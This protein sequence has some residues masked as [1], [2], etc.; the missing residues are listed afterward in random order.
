V[1]GGLLTDLYELNM[2]ASYLRRGM[3]ADATFSLYVRNLPAERGFLVAAGLEACLDLLEDFGFTDN[4]LAYLGSIGFDAR[5]LEDFG[6]VSFDGEVWAVPEGT[7]VYGEEPILEV[8]APIAVAQLVETALL[9][10]ITLHTTIASKAARYIVAAEGRRVVDFAFRR[11]HGAEAAM[12]V[13]RDSSMV[14]FGATSN[15]EA[16]RRY[17]LEVAGTMAHSFVAAFPSE[18]D[19]FVAFAEDHP[20]RTTFLVDTYDTVNGVRTAI[21]VARRLGLTERLA[22]RLDSGDLDDLARASRKLL[23]DAGLT[24]ARIFASGGLDEHEVAELVKA[25]APVD[26]FGIGTQLGVSADAPYVDSVYKLVEYDGEPTMKLS[27]GKVSAPGRKQVWRP[28]DGDHADVLGLRDEDAPEGTTPLL[29][30]V[31]RG[32]TRTSPSPA[33]AELRATFERDLARVPTKARRLQHA[34]HLRVRHTAALDALTARAH[35]EALEHAGLAD[36]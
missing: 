36:G 13:A 34:E 35:L 4:D 11:T 31:M 9:N 26:A 7:I 17:D 6:R 33:I 5:A 16:A 14:G 3:T 15:V 29:A 28:A 10:Q 21:D 19:A 12:A 30:A 20:G 24:T 25:G 32:G 2:A 22:V 23:D 1:P 18:E 8:T 27:S